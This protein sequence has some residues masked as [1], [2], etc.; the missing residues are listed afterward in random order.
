MNEPFRFDLAELHEALHSVDHALIRITPIVTQR[1]LVDFRS[2]GPTGPGVVVLPLVSSLQEALKSIEEARPGLPRPERINV[3]MWPLRV[4]ALERLGVLQALRDRL[5]DM[6]AFDALR[7]L[8]EAYEL[9]LRQERDEL[10]RAVSGDGYATLWP[11][12]KQV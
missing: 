9:L 2:D 5:A 10:Q 8:D 7:Q 1:L 4:A 6:D 12:V 11:A 3:I